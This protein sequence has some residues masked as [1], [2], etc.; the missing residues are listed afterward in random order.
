MGR[1]D[2]E[3]TRGSHVCA[4]SRVE[5][6]LWQR[7]REERRCVERNATKRKNQERCSL[8]PF[9][10]ADLESGRV[11]SNESMTCGT[12]KVTCMCGNENV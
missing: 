10:S 6:R 4:G 9:A 12:S 1:E 11:K 3:T 8:V 2:L 7:G 5:A